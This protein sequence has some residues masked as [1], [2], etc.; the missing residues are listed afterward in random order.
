MTKNE[1]QSELRAKP[2][3]LAPDKP[4]YISLLKEQHF[5]L[6]QLP[7]SPIPQA[8]VDSFGLAFSDMGFKFEKENNQI[9]KG[10]YVAR[11]KCNF[12]KKI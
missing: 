6:Y 11:R 12:Y 4:L 1:E 7:S 10:D 5:F 3:I 2:A 9:R 8:A